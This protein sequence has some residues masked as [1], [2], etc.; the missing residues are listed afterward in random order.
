MVFSHPI[1]NPYSFRR[2]LCSDGGLF[3][4]VLLLLSPTI[5]VLTAWTVLDHFSKHRLM[6][7]HG[8]GYY[9]RCLSNHTALWISLLLAYFFILLIAVIVVAFKTSKIRYKNFRDTKATNIY[10]F[11]VSFST[12]MTLLYWFFFRSLEISINSSGYTLYVGRIF[13]SMPCQF[14]LF[15]PKLY[16]LIVRGLKQW[17]SN[18]KGNNS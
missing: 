14:T 16:P 3:M 12:V 1:F 9:D 10:A 15:I 8:Q 11:L 13:V 6:L 2:K 5:L 17:N 7:P 18:R 4:F